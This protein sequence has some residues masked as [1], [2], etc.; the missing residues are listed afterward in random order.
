MYR[1]AATKAPPISE[2]LNCS[3]PVSLR[4]TKIRLCRWRLTIA[5][6]YQP[7]LPPGH[8]P[9]SDWDIQAHADIQ[10][11]GVLDSIAKSPRF[12]RCSHRARPAL[13]QRASSVAVGLW[14]VRKDGRQLDCELRDHGAWA[15]EVQV[16]LEREFLYGR[17]WAIR[18]LALEKPTNR[19]RGF[20]ARA[21]SSSRNVRPFASGH[22]SPQRG[23]NSGRTGLRYCARYCTRYRRTCQS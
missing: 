22:H 1:P 17:R 10:C 3:W 5:D 12:R 6:R 20:T 15:G 8:G 4:V 7:T 2:K 18:A 9:V 19:R 16:Y 14:A 11:A 23:S 13:P 21:A